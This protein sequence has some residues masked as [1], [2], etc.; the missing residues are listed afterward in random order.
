MVTAKV[1]RL[2]RGELFSFR[3]NGKYIGKANLD[4]DFNVLAR[5][6]LMT[7]GQPEAIGFLIAAKSIL[8]SPKNALLS[9]KNLTKSIGP[10]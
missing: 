6:Y 5:R 10:R 3:L 1:V 2:A 7:A 4:K 9:L 8:R